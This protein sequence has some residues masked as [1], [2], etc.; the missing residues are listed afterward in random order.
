[1][2]FNQT[3]TLRLTTNH[4]KK[5]N[6]LNNGL[7]SLNNRLDHLNGHIPFDL[8][9]PSIDAYKIECKKKLSHS[10]HA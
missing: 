7:N 9:N 10:N 4:L 6:A 2:N 5:N 3:V 8:H 1:M